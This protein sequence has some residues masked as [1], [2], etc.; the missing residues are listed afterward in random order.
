[1]MQVAQ[2]FFFRG[3]SET[4]EC[5]F[6]RGD[7]PPRVLFVSE[8]D[9]SDVGAKLPVVVSA[10]SS[11]FEMDEYRACTSI[12]IPTIQAKMRHGFD[13]VRTVSGESH[14]HPSGGFSFK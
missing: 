3:A 9:A 1:L 5:E 2:A 6:G 13:G 11:S 14:D 4:Y 7:G 10:T 12:L 8:G